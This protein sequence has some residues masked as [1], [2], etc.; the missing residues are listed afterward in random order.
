MS[1]VVLDECSIEYT[2]DSTC[3]SLRGYSREVSFG[4]L[5]FL[6]KLDYLQASLV[7]I[8]VGREGSIIPNVSFDTSLQYKS[9]IF[10]CFPHKKTY[11]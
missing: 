4:L 7:Q 5:L 9:K 10:V 8:K 1:I 3:I 6:P 11:I 2:R